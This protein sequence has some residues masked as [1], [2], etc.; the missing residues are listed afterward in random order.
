MDHKVLSSI[1]STKPSPNVLRAARK[2]R[3]FSVLGMRSCA[4]GMGARS[5]M[6]ERLAI[7]LAPSLIG[8]VAATKFR[9]L[10]G[11]QARISVNWLEAPLTGFVGQAAH[12]L[13]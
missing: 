1:A 3:M 7:V 6:I 13:A 4:C 12:A 5:F 9:S 11:C 8:T 2:A 10:S